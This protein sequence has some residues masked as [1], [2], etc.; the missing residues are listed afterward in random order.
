MRVKK[1]IKKQV[2]NSK[3]RDKLRVIIELSIIQIM[4]IRILTSTIQKLLLLLKLIRINLYAII[5][6]FN[7]IKGN[8]YIYIWITHIYIYI[9]IYT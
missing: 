4:Y 5:I 2:K 1:V 8:N 9:Y 3:N 6:Y 7:A